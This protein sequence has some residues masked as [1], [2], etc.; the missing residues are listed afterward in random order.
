MCLFP[1]KFIFVRLEKLILRRCG[2]VGK[3]PAFQSGVPGSIPSDVRHLISI[4]GLG[5]CPLSVFCPVLTTAVALIL[6]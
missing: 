5:V 3:V 4:F 1:V 2:V 6:H